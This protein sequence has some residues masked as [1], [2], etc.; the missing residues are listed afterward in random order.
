MEEK[1]EAIDSIDQT[2]KDLKKKIQEITEKE[3]QVS[4][5]SGKISLPSF[6]IDEEKINEIKNV[7]KE[8]I[9]DSIDFIKKKT[10]DFTNDENFEKTISFLREN[11]LKAVEVAKD[12]S[13]NEKVVDK[14]SEVKAKV[15]EI[16]NTAFAT[17]NEKISDETKEKIKNAIADAGEKI[18]TTGFDVK[19][20]VI[21]FSE[22]P[23]VQE[24]IQ[25]V[26]DK[27]LDTVDKG[28]E[29]VQNFVNKK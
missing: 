4:V 17:V 22:K 28:L 23:E 14:I 10:S 21:D 3:S 12:I 18:V 27:A 5:E 7:S 24:K 19:K 29:V 8:V 13:T 6:K 1:K 9:E 15:T 20:K 26:K 16:K 2:I 11:A 25:L